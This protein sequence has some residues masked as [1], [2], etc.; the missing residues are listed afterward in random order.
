[1]LSC[2]KY[3]TY[4]FYFHAIIHSLVSWILVIFLAFW[5]WI[6][7]FDAADFVTLLITLPF[8]SIFSKVL[9]V[10][11]S[12]KL[13]YN[14][15]IVSFLITLL[16]TLYAKVCHLVPVN[17]PELNVLTMRVLKPRELRRIPY[18]HLSFYDTL[19]YDAPGKAWKSGAGA[20]GTKL[21]ETSYESAVPWQVVKSKFLLD[22]PAFFDPRSGQTIFFSSPFLGKKKSIDLPVGHWPII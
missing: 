5:S 14:F 4:P 15:F 21:F 7:W 17:Y 2:Y 19:R 12:N 3:F 8:F 10:M 22:Y 20:S 11:G 13:C 6:L 18:F 16:L 9:F 1:M